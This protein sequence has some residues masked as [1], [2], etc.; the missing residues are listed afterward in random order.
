VDDSADTTRDADWAQVWNLT[1]PNA[2]V[3]PASKA[4]ETTFSDG[5]NIMI[6][7]Q[8]PQKL[9]VEEAVG[10]TSSSDSFPKT[11]IV[12][13]HQKTDN[14]RFA[15]LLYPYKAGTRPQ[16]EWSRILPDVPS[17]DLFYSIKVITEEGLDWSVFGKC[18]QSTL[19]RKGRH[20]ADADFAIVRTDRKGHFRSFSRAFGKAFTF[21]GKTLATAGNRVFDL[22][23]SYEGDTVRINAKEPESTLA[24]RMGEAKAVVLNGKTIAKPV[25][26]DGMCYPFA[27]MPVT[28]VADDRDAFERVTQGNEWTRVAD[29]NS[30]STGYTHHETDPGRHENGNYV[31]NVPSAGRYGVEV[32]VPD[33]TM[34]PS[35]RIDYRIPASGT[36]VA[37][38]GA[39]VNVKQD[40]DAYVITV[41]HQT[42]AGWVKLG[43]FDLPAGALK[44]NAKN[45]TEIDGI[46]FTADAMRL[47][48]K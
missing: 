2:K 11:K 48:K 15:T 45:M 22:A 23:V 44:I 7:N 1:D 26:K 10:M 24:V 12:R 43:D 21:K 32:S 18:G 33:I 39:V 27:G 35:D 41:N 3:D 4:I 16:V 34:V 13:L 8:D 29:P 6:L 14:P 19:Y 47:V 37:V 17:N 28:I 40:G 25:V 31:F 38:A 5:G 36:P 20:D 42:K 30:W 9:T 46:Y